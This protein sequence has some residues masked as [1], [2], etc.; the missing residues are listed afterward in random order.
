M[1]S[2]NTFVSAVL[3]LFIYSSSTDRFQAITIRD[4]GSLHGTSVN[5]LSLRPTETRVVNSGDVVSFGLAIDRGADTFV[6]Q[7]VEATISWKSVSAP[8]VVTYCVPDDTD[9]EELSDKDDIGL[10]EFPYARR[11]ICTNKYRGTNHQGNKVD[12][13]SPALPPFSS[14]DNP[15]SHVS[16]MVDLTKDEYSFSQGSLFESSKKT[17]MT[18]P[19]SESLPKATSDTAAL[20]PDLENKSN[21]HQGGDV[22]D[23][24]DGFGELDDESSCSYESDIGDENDC[25]GESEHSYSL[26]YPDEKLLA[27]DL[28]ES[29]DGVED[30]DDKGENLQDEN[31]ED[32]EIEEDWPIDDEVSAVLEVD[33]TVS[34]VVARNDDLAQHSMDQPQESPTAVTSHQGPDEAPIM[35]TMD[36]SC[37][38]SVAPAGLTHKVEASQSS[39]GYGGPATDFGCGHHDTPS[40]SRDRTEFFK[41]REEN[42]RTL[43]LVKKPETDHGFDQVTHALLRSGE[44]FL[45]QP[46]QAPFTDFPS[47]AKETPELNETSAYQFEMSK[48]AATTA[49]QIETPGDSFQQHRGTIEPKTHSSISK[50]KAIDIS[51]STAAEVEAL[52]KNQAE[53]T[54]KRTITSMQGTLDAHRQPRLSADQCGRPIK[55]LRR[56]AEVVG[57]AAIGGIAVMSALIATAPQL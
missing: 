13:T 16:A 19:S 41:A 17:N 21:V 8:K 33:A 45:N 10:T 31:I 7:E 36:P 26:E 24:A 39:A 52:N 27:D 43:G 18:Q 23:P 47:A 3:R 22:L 32:G 9:V 42:R 55:R 2:I 12:L 14:F 51:D 4:T 1:T 56:A 46:P 38:P 54:D 28:F 15:G 5:R 48:R 11:A 30:E 40:S 34:S 44:G 37:Q 49:S 50:R 35:A 6:P 57:Y 25:S 20:S 29:S 53:K